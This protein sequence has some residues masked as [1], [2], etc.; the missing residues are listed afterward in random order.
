MPRGVFFGLMMMFGPG[1]IALDEVDLQIV[2][3][4][5]PIYLMF[6]ALIVLYSACAALRTDR[7]HV[8]PAVDPGP[9]MKRATAAVQS[10]LALGITFMAV[11]T[12]YDVHDNSAAAYRRTIAAAA[13]ASSG[14]KRPTPAR[15]GRGVS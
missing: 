6:V 4:E 12:T 11:F 2:E 15:S 8:A 3:P 7:L 13:R 1:I 14:N 5:V 9:R 10:L